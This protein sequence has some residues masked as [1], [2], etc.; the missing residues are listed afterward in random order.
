MIP[1]FIRAYSDWTLWGIRRDLRRSP[2]AGRSR[3]WESERLKVIEREAQRRGLDDPE[4]KGGR[5]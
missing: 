4:D 1:I 2:M 3:S 5:P